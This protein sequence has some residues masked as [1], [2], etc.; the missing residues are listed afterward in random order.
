M[1]TLQEMHGS[2]VDTQSLFKIET[3]EY[4]QFRDALG[5]LAAKMQQCGD[6]A[7]SAEQVTDLR[8]LTAKTKALYETYYEK[9]TGAKPGEQAPEGAKEPKGPDKDRLD[10]L[11]GLNDM[12]DGDLL[13]LQNHDVGKA[14][15]R[16]LD[17][18]LSDNRALSADV[19]G[20][21]VEMVGVGISARMVLENNGTKGV[22]SADYIVESSDDVLKNIPGEYPQVSGLFNY[23]KDH[24]GMLTN[25][26]IQ[27]YKDEKAMA[28]A[29]VKKS[30]PSLND[31]IDDLQQRLPDYCFFD[32]RAFVDQFAA[33]VV[34]YSTAKS[35]HLGSSIAQIDEG[36]N[37]P[38]RNAAMTMVADRL[39]IPNI[40][41]RSKM[42]NVQTDKGLKKGVFME[43][44]KGMDLADKVSKYKEI[45]EFAG[46]RVSFSSPDLLKSA[47]DLQALDYI[48]GNTDRHHGNMMYQ[49]EERNGVMV[50]V[51]IQGID[52][53][54]SFGKI[55]GDKNTGYL[56]SPDSMRVMKKSTAENI[57][58]MTKEELSYTLY[59]MVKPDEIDKAWER[60]QKL[61]ETIRKSMKMSWKN[62][63]SIRTDGIHIIDDDSPAWEKLDLKE[64]RA[65][66]KRGEKDSG[67]FEAIAYQEKE[68]QKYLS[69]NKIQEPKKDPRAEY[70]K[71]SEE[72]CLYGY[73]YEVPF[74]AE[75]MDHSTRDVFLLYRNRKT[76]HEKPKSIEIGADCFN[77]MMEK[78]GFANSQIEKDMGWK[79]GLDL[80]YIDGKK[81]SEYVR[82]YSPDNAD[83]MDYVKAQ[84]MAAITSG[85]HH[86]D[87]VQI[88]TDSTGHFK[89]YATELSMNLSAMKGQE[90]FLEK[91]RQSRAKSLLEDEKGRIRRQ[92]AIEAEVLQA[93]NTIADEKVKNLAP[94]QPAIQRPA[95]GG[96][97][98]GNGRNSGRNGEIIREPIDLNLLN[99]PAKGTKQEVKQTGGVKNMKEM[100]EPKKK[101]GKQ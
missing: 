24:I 29:I 94:A 8:I 77:E 14:P 78:V 75:S 18:V 43:W 63:S 36:R 73:R 26:E 83:N 10:I 40:A 31:L 28:D 9:I 49:F 13:A 95:P 54:S 41:A 84:V 46:K 85:R 16:T 86:V 53:D 38:R 42:M 60:T 67:V 99:P 74:P 15:E 12:L 30:D 71:E 66:E 23:F 91:S 92:T 11:N 68:Y 51:G 35:G 65:N 64:L 90:R 34:R 4:K 37:I 2:L 81:A 76:L 97:N 17:E 6:A 22:F 59:G 20:K 56:A 80:I 3:T 25:F 87:M 96:K 27:G 57:L 39:G 93:A 7:L 82:K 1:P 55:T 100:F 62:D 72:S 44:G 69:R 61:Q 32:S 88:R 70:Y 52:N 5:A 58:R 45:P 98:G 50:L 48:C 47:S 79:N 101:K 89:T 33:A 19:R 21:Q